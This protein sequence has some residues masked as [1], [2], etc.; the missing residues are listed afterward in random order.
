MPHLA[1]QLGSDSVATV[2]DLPWKMTPPPKKKKKGG[3]GRG[4]AGGKKPGV[5]MSDM[6][7]FLKHCQNQ[8]CSGIIKREERERE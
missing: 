1:H 3:G 6:L 5:I 2:T 4:N 8:A 7:V